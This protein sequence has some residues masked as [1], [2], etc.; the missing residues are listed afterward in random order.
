[1]EKHSTSNVIGTVQSEQLI[2]EVK[3][4]ISTSAANII[5]NHDFCWGLHLWHRN[6][7]CCDAYV[8][9]SGLSSGGRFAVITNRSEDWQGL[10]QDITERVSAGSVYKVCAWVGISG[11][12]GA[13]AD[14]IATLKIENQDKSLTFLHTAAEFF[15]SLSV[16]LSCFK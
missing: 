4:S 1:M 13:V 11:A 6:S 9:P 7:N 15:L 8:V 2:E 5:L 12:H 10:E 14:V 16:C 3:V